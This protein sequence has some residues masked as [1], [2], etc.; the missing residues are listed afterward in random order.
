[1]SADFFGSPRPWEWMPFH[2]TVA[3]RKSLEINWLQLLIDLLSQSNLFAVK[4]AACKIS[5]QQIFYKD[6]QLKYRQS[7]LNLQENIWALGNLDDIRVGESK[8]AVK[9][10]NSPNSH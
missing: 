3:A 2:W 10:V 1:M 5:N 6:F 4:T 7:A 9:L 8:I